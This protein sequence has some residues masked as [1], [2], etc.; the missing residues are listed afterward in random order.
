MPLIKSALKADTKS[1]NYRAIAIS[2]LLL[3]VL[4]NVI[5]ILFGDKLSS[6]WLQFGY[7]RGTSGTQ[8]SWM[9]LE[10]VSYYKRQ[11][12]TVQGAFLDCSKTFDNCV[13]STLFKKVLDR[14]PPAIIVRGVLAIYRKQMCWI[15]WSAGE[16]CSRCFGVS[17][18]T[19]QGSCLSP[20]LF[21]VYLDDLL[22]LLR[23]S[24]IGC[25]VGDVFAG[26]GCFADDLAILAPTRDALQIM[27]SICE[28]YAA[29][30][31]LTFSTDPDPRKSKS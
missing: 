28:S 26:A 2:S 19:R 23:E 12:T 1:S 6:D 5:I 7:K 16:L 8:C 18:G 10:V 24:G 9:I 22:I 29:S 30:H 4:D 11:N 13:H 17:N 31:N 27:L 14:D 21:A 25:Y 3:K 20:C 15:R